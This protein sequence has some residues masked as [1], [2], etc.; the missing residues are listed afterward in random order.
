M[1]A[2]ER[3]VAEKG[4]LTD[5]LVPKHRFLGHVNS[6]ISKS[7]VYHKVDN[8]GCLDSTLSANLDGKW[9]ALYVYLQQV[10]RRIGVD[11]NL[12]G[13]DVKSLAGPADV[14]N[15]WVEGVSLHRSMENRRYYTVGI[16]GPPSSSLVHWQRGSQYLTRWELLAG[17]PNLS[18]VRHSLKKKTPLS[19]CIRN[20]TRRPHRTSHSARR[21]LVSPRRYARVNCLCIR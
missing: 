1:Y 18:F 7:K 5:F 2:L 6:A 9:S 14:P 3:V 13:V 12:G 16:V 21:I 19:G 20:K 11:V 4:N 8:R 10:P 15:L 17:L